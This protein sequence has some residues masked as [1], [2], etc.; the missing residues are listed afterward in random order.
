MKKPSCNVTRRIKKRDI[1]TDAK[2]TIGRFIQGSKKHLQYIC[3]DSGICI[4]FGKKTEEINRFFKGFTDFTY[5]R[6]PVKQIGKS[7]ANGF[8]KEI[9]YEKEGYKAYAVLKSSQREESDNLVYEYLVGTKYVNRIMNR[10]P[11][12]LE[13]YGLYFYKDEPHWKL[14]NTYEPVNVSNL[15]RMELQSR[16]NYSKA[17]ENSKHAAVL[18]QHIKGAMPISD[19]LATSNYSRFIKNDLL[20]ILFIIYHALSSISTHF[21]HYDLHD[22]NVLLYEPEKGKYIQYYYHH[23]DGSE[24]VFYSPYIPK[25]I[26][27]GRSYFNNGNVTSRKIYDRICKVNDCNPNCGQ[28]QGFTWLEPTPYYEISS[29]LKNESHDLRLMNIIRTHMEYLFDNHQTKPSDPTVVELHNIVNYVTYGIGLDKSDETKGTEENLT[30][31]SPDIYNVS[32]AYLELKKGIQKL[33][34]KSENERNYNQFANLLGV[35]HIY[36][37]GRPMKYESA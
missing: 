4:A 18:L 21:T 32:G 22:G 33:K 11:C 31:S 12:F 5:A 16:I 8:V 9:A 2:K 35:L 30:I 26:D 37:D 19:F 7:S 23:T 14:L 10:F 13:T 6:S 27:Y 20:Y 34:V 24:T 15:Q 1:E 28:N 3:S 25:I 17:C 36:D 29:S